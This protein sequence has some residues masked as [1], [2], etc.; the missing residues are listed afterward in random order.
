MVSSPIPR[1][2]AVSSPDAAVCPECGTTLEPDSRFCP[3]CGHP[4]EPHAPVGDDVTDCDKHDGTEDDG[5]QTVGGFDIDEFVHTASDAP[6]A[7][8]P[9]H[10]DHGDIDVDALGS[11][12]AS[13]NVTGRKLSRKERKAA[14]KEAKRLAREAKQS[15][16]AAKKQYASVKSQL[17]DRDKELSEKTESFRR[18]RES[19]K[20]VVS[21][22][23]YDRMFQDGICEVEDGLFS[24]SLSF[25]DTSYHSVRDEQ[26]K[27]MFS[28]LTRLYDSFGADTLVQ[29]SVVNTPLLKEEVG[30]RQFF[31]VNRQDN[32]AARHD[33][34]VFNDILNDKVREGVS[35]IRRDR[36]LTY[37]VTAETADDAARK[38]SRI[39]TECSRILN[40]MGSKAHPMNGT[41]R[42]SIIH[43]LLNPFKPFYFDYQRDISARSVQT[44][45]DCIAPGQID[46][47][48][49]GVLNDCVRLDNGVYAQ[50]LVMRKFGSELSDRAL[51]DMVDLPVPM[52]V[53]WYVQPMDKSKAINFVRTRSAWI[54]KEIIEEQRSAVN[55][56][57]DFSILPQE[58][59]Y[60]KEETEDV[61]DHLQNKNQRLYVFTGL[62]YT[63][64]ESKEKLDQQVM[65][66]ISV[67]RQSSIEVDTYDYRQRRG[68]NS[69][70][71]LGHNHVEI[72]R[73]FTTAQVSIL[74]P[75]ATQELDDKGG[76]YYGQNKH[77]RNLVICNRKLL[78]SPMGFVCG[79][80]GSGKGMFTKTEMTGTIFSNPTDEIYVIDR[81]GEYTG[82]AERYGGTVYHFGVGT[83]TYLNP[84]DTVSVSHMSRPE[85]IAFK[86]D[87]MLA[88]AGASA[89]ESGTPLSEVEQSII[90]RCVEFAFDRAEERGDGLPPTLQ[91]FYDIAREQSERQAQ[92]IA[93][94]YE[95]FVKGSMDFFN[96][97]SNIGWDSR[98]VDF[99][100]KNLPDSMLVFA[101]INVCEAVRNRMYFNA[102]RGVRTW[103]YVEEMQS[104]FAYPTVLN[105]FSRF[106]NEGRKFGL[107][108]T[109]ITQNA[110]A[111]LENEAARNIVL[112]A[113]FI[114]LLKQS[115]LDRMRWAELLNLS[116]QEEEC[117]DESAEA[118]DGLLLAGGARVPILG[119]F[120][121]G[122]VLYD[123]FS[124][125]PNETK[126]DAPKRNR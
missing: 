66:I 123:L 7:G 20:D 2:Q 94:K 64:A 109:G 41:Q 65:R 9:G 117:I 86:I 4:V 58:L 76:N 100:L 33:A 108:L 112:N 12:V 16:R 71:P 35:N 67:A 6:F 37:S 23:G 46:F 63:Y 17:K 21:Y 54:D 27:A 110:T 122:N 3:I 92:V 13:T 78:T 70:L 60:S 107:L 95:R 114:M 118:G 55:K 116:E 15:A 119:R 14:K 36:Y 39:E 57:Y 72:S 88:Q 101:L 48:P 61:L 24:A 115:P 32:D 51:A 75:F 99:N 96:H 106:S 59:K 52:C 81:A 69:V 121:K 22:I 10:D 45:K 111:M 105:Y 82:I 125:N 89:E 77:S 68:L 42:L 120:P 31:D 87:A 30:N 34:A 93:L 90:Q 50:V 97:Q 49:D 38:L 28:A 5:D 103:L 26:Q 62:V 74:V 29:M 44:T 11:A 124:T 53:T 102:K 79:K 56:G 98:I 91:D 47:K 40:S 85:Q 113:D 8:R 104:M 43:S 1:E 19:A 84:F 18:K 126:A 73:M 25:D 83:G 80:T